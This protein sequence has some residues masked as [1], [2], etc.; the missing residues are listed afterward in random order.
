MHCLISF[1][2]CLL[3]S[4][5]LFPHADPMPCH[6][7]KCWPTHL[8]PLVGP[9]LCVKLS[10]FGARILSKL[11]KWVG[12][13]ET[14]TCSKRENNNSF[15]ERAHSFLLAIRV[16]VCFPLGKKKPETFFGLPSIHHH[17]IFEHAH[18]PFF[19]SFLCFSKP[20]GTLIYIL[21]TP[22]ISIFSRMKLQH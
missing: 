13:P 10:C 5:N 22:I 18:V 21:F 2:F 14:M 1:Q 12:V 19:H 8:R 17:L 4:P 20:N 6:T 3:F 11:I 9:F 7:W 16:S 15:S